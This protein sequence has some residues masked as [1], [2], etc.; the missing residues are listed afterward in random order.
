[1][2]TQLR[3]TDTVS[4]ETFNKLIAELE[5]AFT[6]VNNTLAGLSKENS[7]KENN[8]FEKSVTVN[9]DIKVLGEIYSES[10]FTSSD[11][12]FKKD[13]EEIQNG[14]EKILELKAYTYEK[15]D[16]RESGFKASE[17]QQLMKEC[18]VEVD[19]KLMVRYEGIIPYLVSSIHKL[20][21]E[22]EKMKK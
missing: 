9:K 21:E 6:N 16:K 10:A 22:I 14:L 17:V 15:N 5:A 3:S 12:R 13:F 1:M 19:G 18:V 4:T 8:T 20:H 7:F 11:E 2:L